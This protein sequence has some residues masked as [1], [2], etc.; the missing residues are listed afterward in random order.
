MGG[1]LPCCRDKATGEDKDTDRY[2]AEIMPLA[3]VEVESM[4]EIR[5]LEEQAKQVDKL[6]ITRQHCKA[7]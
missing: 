1:R 4:E 2:V 6:E 5:R 7:A 3:C